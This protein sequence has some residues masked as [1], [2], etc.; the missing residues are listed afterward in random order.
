MRQLDLC[1]GVTLDFG[2]RVRGVA[3]AVGVRGGDPPR[4]RRPGHRGPDRGEL[5]AGR[6]AGPCGD[7]RGQQDRPPSCA[8]R[9]GDGGNGTEPG[10]GPCRRAHRER[11]DRRGHRRG[12]RGGRCARG[13]A[14]GRH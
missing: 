2:V 14:R 5:L 11:E 10:G 9:G 1:L 13:G 12:A 6:G 4:R 7:P 3:C 8:D